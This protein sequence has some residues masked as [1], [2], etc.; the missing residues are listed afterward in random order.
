MKRIVIGILAHVDSGKTTLSEGMLYRCGELRKMGRVDHGD[1]FL[2]TNEIEREKGITIFSKQA[3]MTVGQTEI[4]LLDTPGHIDFSAETERTLGVLDYAILVVSGSEGV[5]NHTET[6]WK[7]LARYNVPT[8]IFINKMDISQLDKTEL[9]SALRSRLSDGCVDFGL[10]GT[11]DFNAWDL[12]T[13]TLTDAALSQAVM[14][15]QL[16]PCFFGSALKL[17]NIDA[18]LDAL[19]NYTVMPDY[20][21]EFGARVFK[22]STDENGIRLTHMKITGGALRSKAVIIGADSSGEEWSEKA[23]RLRL[24]NGE[25][26]DMTVPSFRVAELLACI[27][28]NTN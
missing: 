3:R 25:K 1:T 13:D 19:E 8:F 14:S 12:Q 2:D 10:R 26:F 20:P 7:L 24:Y 15:R 4:T 27:A 9:T 21:D 11:P 17:I 28:A 5:Q 18:L 23:D 6:L 16:F 22:I